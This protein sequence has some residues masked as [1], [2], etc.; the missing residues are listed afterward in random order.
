[1]N[2]PLTISNVRF[3]AG[4]PAMV[5][6]GVLGFV[7]ATVNSALRIDGVAVRRTRDGRLTLSYPAREDNS[8]RQH[9]LFCPIND[10]VR[11]EIEDRV[12]QALGI[13]EAAS[14]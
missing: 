10:E 2:G 12:F 6:Q 14:S 8:G 7:A 11:R 5:A 3:S 1:M 4:T 13:E 9:A